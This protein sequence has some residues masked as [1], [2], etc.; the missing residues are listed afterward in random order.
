MDTAKD[1]SFNLFNNSS[2]AKLVTRLRPKR[3]RGQGRVER[4]T[5]A[6]DGSLYHVPS[7]VNNVIPCTQITRQGLTN[8][9]TVKTGMIIKCGRLC[10]VV[11]PIRPRNYLLR[12]IDDL[13]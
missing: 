6:R 12:P 7:L 11:P 9:E 10:L 2:R 1:I 3:P 13:L 8:V 4:I 5:A